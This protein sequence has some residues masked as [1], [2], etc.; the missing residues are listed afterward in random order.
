MER[1]FSRRSFIGL[2]AIGAATA[3]SLTACTPQA[4]A[5]HTADSSNLA[6]TAA[7]EIAEETTIP[8]IDHLEFFPP[9]GA[10]VAYVDEPISDDDVVE[11]V[12][13]DV[14]ICGAGMS[15]VAAAASASENGLSVVLLEKGTTFAAR[16]TE[17]AAF[18]DRVHAE[19]DIVLSALDFMND[20]LSTAHFRCDRSVWERWCERSGEALDWAMD[21]VGDACGSFTAK[22]A[23]AEFC[24]VTTWGS[25]VRIE[26]GI[27]SFVETL[28]GIAEEHGADIRYN[29]PAIQL[30]TQ[31]GKVTGVYA[32]SADGIIKIEAAKG[33]VLATGGYEFN[34][35]M[36]TQRIRPRDLAVYAW[37]NPTITNTGDGILMGLAAGAAEDDWPHI[38]MNDPAG[39]KTGNRA[40]GAMP[41]FLRV[42]ENG[43]R[44]VN[45]N[46]SFEY[47]SNAIMYQP[48]AHDFVLLSGTDILS[49]IEKAKGGAPWTSEEMY[50]SIKDVLVEASTLDELAEKCGINASNLTQTVARYNEL[51]ASGEDADFGKKPSDLIPLEEGPY[52]AIEESGCCLVTVNGLRID[53]DSRVLTGTGAPIEGLYALGNASG[54]MFNGTYPHHMSAISHGRCL[55]FGYLVGRR[56]AGLEA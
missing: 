52:Y 1:N 51:C 8:N 45:E 3:A 27:A 34:W 7:D 41:A 46:L 47:M 25:G 44:F 6:S 31:D 11:T 24:G 56:L 29:T 42:N 55:T 20:G 32:K 40:N 4:P 16:G 22:A 50:D 21:A 30:A 36:L 5:T 13:C 14:A 33:V 9:N 12:S 15:G 28:I 26:K 39:A 54:S 37:I 23:N 53:A 38:L 43:E 18:G 17:I 49:S 2:S 19:A 48:G 10:E 35:D